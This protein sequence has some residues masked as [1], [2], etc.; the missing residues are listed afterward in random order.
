MRLIFTRRA[1][2]FVSSIQVVANCI[3]GIGL[4]IDKRESVIERKAAAMLMIAALGS[5]IFLVLPPQTV[6]A[7]N[8]APA[9]VG[10]PPEP[11][12]LSSPMTE[13]PGLLLIATNLATRAIDLL[14]PKGVFEAIVTPITPPLPPDP[15]IWAQPTN[16]TVTA[17]TITKT[18]GCDGCADAGAFSQQKLT[19]GNGYME[20]TASSGSRGYIGLG[21]NIDPQPPSNSH[22]EINFGIVFGSNNSWSVRE[23]NYTYRYE[24]SYNSN[25]VFQIAVVG[26]EVWYKQN[27]VVKFIS[28]TT[29]SYPLVVDTS[30]IT[31]GDNIY[32]T[33]VSFGQGNPPPATL[34][35]ERLSPKNATGGTN[36]YSQNFSWGTSLVNLPGRAGMDLNLGIGYNSL[37]W[38]KKGSEIVF[39]PDTNNVSPGFQFGFP[40]LETAYNDGG[41]GP[42]TYLMVTPDGGRKE[43]RQVGSSTTY[44]TADSSYTQLVVNGATITVTG[45]DS[46]Q[47]SYSWKVNAFKCTQIK[48]RNGNYI[49][50]TYNA[51][52]GVL[53]SITDTL[54]RVINI[55][56]TNSYPTSITQ[57]WK[58]ANGSGTDEPH[59]WATF[60]YTNATVSTN[61]SGMTVVGP[62]NNSTVK[63]L[64]K[65]TFSDLSY[66]KFTYN[67]YLQVTMV[68]S[69]AADAHRLNYVSPGYSA[70]NPAQ[71]CPRLTQTQTQAENFNG[72]SP[73][74]VTNSAPAPSTY[75]LPDGHTGPAKLITV[76][77]TNDP[78][79]GLYSNMYVGDSGYTEG[80]TL[81]T[82]DCVSNC[83]GANQKRWTWT[84]WTQDDVNL[85]YILNP[86]VTE[87]R[88]GDGTNT[89]KTTIGYYHDSTTGI[90]LPETVS[91]G[92]LSTVLKTQKTDYN[93]SQTYTSRRIIGLPLETKQWEGN[94]STLMSKVT[95]IYDQ[96]NMTGSD[97]V[98]NISP[99][100]HD[101]NY[102]SSFVIGRGLVTTTTRWDATAPNTPGSAVS[103]T[104]KYNTAGAPVS[105]T[106]PLSRT[107]KISYADVWNDGVSRT[108]YAYPTTI[109]DPDG[110]GS[111]VKYRYDIGANV[112]A[113]SPDL[114]ATTP[115]KTTTREYLDPLARLTK[116]RIENNGA[117]TRY[118]YF[119]NGTQFKSFSTVV[120]MTEVISETL[121]D[122]AGRVLMARTEHP[123]S[124]G[125]WSA[126]KTVYDILGRI[127]SQSIPTEVNNGWSPT[128]D[129]AGSWKYNS[130]EYDWKGRVTKTINPDGTFKTIAY[131]GCGCAGGETMTVEG[132]A[133]TETDWQGN[134]TQTLGKRKQKLYSDVLGRNI[135]GETF[136]WNGTVYST[137]VNSYNGRDQ[138]TQSRQFDGNEFSSANQ[139]ATTVYDGHGR[140]QATH[141][142]SQA[143]NT[144]TTYEYFGD[145]SVKKVT[146][147]R[148]ASSN[149]TYNN[150][151]LVEEISYAVPTNSEGAT[152]WGFRIDKTSTSSFKIFGGNFANDV[153]VSLV[154]PRVWPET[155]YIELATL[156]NGQ[157]TRS[158]QDGY[159]TIAVQLT[160]QALTDALAA[161]L[162][163]VKVTNTNTGQAT[164]YMFLLW[165]GG[166]SVYGSGFP[167]TVA[168]A[169][170]VSF[171]YDYAGN[172]ISMTDQFGTTTYNYDQLSRLTSETR[173]ISTISQ[174]FTIGYTYDLS[175]QLKTITDGFNA[176]VSY[177]YNRAGKLTAVSG[178]NYGIGSPFMSNVKYRSWGAMKEAD[179]GYGGSLD[180]TYNNRMLPTEFK[181]TGA[182]IGQSSTRGSSYSY[183]A[184]GQLRKSDD[185]S[186]NR[187]DRTFKY[188]HTARL[189]E[190]QSGFEAR[191]ESNPDP[192]PNRP[193]KQTYAYDAWN[194][195]TGGEQ[196]FWRKDL[197]SLVQRS[198]VNNR[199]SDTAYDSD[200]R[201]LT[202]Q[203]DA[204]DNLVENRSRDSV[205]GGTLP[206]QNAF[207]ISQKF[208]GN[209]DVGKRTEIK[210]RDE[211]VNGVPTVVEDPS[212][213]NV[214]YLRS[215]VLGGKPVAEIDATS[216]T[217]SKGYIYANGAL[218]AE[219][220]ACVGCN[221][222]TY[223]VWHEANPLT[224]GRLEVWSGGSSD[225]QERDPMGAN[226]GTEDPWLYEDYPT[227]SDII[228]E[229]PL[230]LESGGNP[231]DPNSPYEV[232]GI[233]VSREELERRM[234]S[235]TVEGAI[236]RGGRYEGSFILRNIS[237][238][239]YSGTLRREL[240]IPSSPEVPVENGYEFW[241]EDMY[242][243]NLRS[244]YG[245]VRS[246]RGSN[247]TEPPRRNPVRP[248]H[249]IPCWELKIKPL[250]LNPKSIFSDGLGGAGTGM[251]Q[252]GGSFRVTRG[253]NGAPNP[254]AFSPRVYQSNWGGGS[255]ARIAT[256]S[257][258]G[259]GTFASRGTFVLS[260]GLAG[261]DF[262]NAYSQ[263]GR[264][265][266]NSQVEAARGVGGLAGSLAGAKAGAATGAFVGAF[267]EGVGAAPGAIVGGIIGGIGGGISG[268]YVAGEAV[269]ALQ[270]RSSPRSR[271]P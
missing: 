150:R 94:S 107:V 44:E 92:D 147:A 24:D 234:G 145:D 212:A 175:G 112:W 54:G 240:T 121:T 96:G 14:S 260:A 258:T 34:A 45:T 109:T 183:Y 5:Q 135:R 204:A 93:W 185:L 90:R 167:N 1:A 76:A 267:F 75:N 113:K 65:I 169:P 127:T 266:P 41:S 110:H 39:N 232:D 261:Y 149:Y 43:F 106:D 164:P 91:V 256:H 247:R 227:Y 119:D 10:A 38:I 220:R 235:G 188:D 153:T 249:V 97:P 47:M 239:G 16:V 28:P 194:N 126:T 143:A 245:T 136:N 60:D 251:N 134:T 108:T 156:T 214:Y 85:G 4:R 221:P 201:S 198:F 250:V 229:H 166:E 207:E 40:I 17:T 59:T 154:K 222:S 241:D 12:V 48:D 105:Q 69:Y 216:G 231:F 187:F 148:G 79:S 213:I 33:T 50:N 58:A 61:F 9:Q 197:S 37:V 263:E 30:L 57:T 27:G 72:G 115:G 116:E 99:T 230:Y 219:Q 217:K 190:A 162:L 205:G 84:G 132:E 63:V 193:F 51:T 210:R 236:F 209:G 208:D 179:F 77:V 199:A 176:T 86:R 131:E 36:L 155:G 13:T 177:D 70:T 165:W 163:Q 268:S 172:R 104:A 124:F 182:L 265:G 253:A 49:S 78:T 103:S 46:T 120:D 257:M 22:L 218:L 89:K 138:I 242:F 206:V 196:R 129:D 74:I 15:V 21:K 243:P 125:G 259:V 118:Q 42:Y 152:P 95:Y 151:G 244:D 269:Q 140:P 144:N 88:V 83:T 81:A 248:K 3:I 67:G 215:S 139:E 55:N 130:S 262:Y 238:L 246:M 186:D 11:F 20:F 178:T 122:G 68:E 52:T 159:Q 191:G 142:P 18:G 146:D 25:D 2:R 80:L 237:A 19:S 226:T 102:G 224:G 233:P 66:T 117:Y 168:A 200:G 203:I 173:Q 195:R 264:F 252:V 171:A 62:A 71:D 73:V 181:M 6:A 56:Y 64:E 160:T 137:F 128:G 53:E 184:D 211:E 133:I 8:T 161:D 29:P 225:T 228:D 270:D 111:T 180:M 100:Q 158:T 254:F 101:T 271:C 114:N 174:S 141:M 32:N 31:A 170:P 255:S 7:K 98:Q 223:I 26:T 87:T 192:Q 189:K 202:S 35:A 82:Q 123:D 23:L 157:L